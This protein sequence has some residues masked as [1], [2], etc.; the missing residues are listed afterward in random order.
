MIHGLI[1]RDNISCLGFSHKRS[2]TDL[3]RCIGSNHQRMTTPFRNYSFMLECEK[4][5]DVNE[6]LKWFHHFRVNS[7]FFAAAYLAFVFIGPKWM[8]QRK[9]YELR[10]PLICWNIAIAVFSTLGALRTIPEVIHVT[11][12]IGLHHSVCVA[13]CIITL[14]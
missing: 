2:V 6:F 1:R 11:R 5:F 9:P 7:F 13:R 8:A 4:N 12:N 14:S 10:G 3:T